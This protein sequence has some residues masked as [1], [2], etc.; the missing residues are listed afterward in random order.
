MR[1][2]LVISTVVGSTLLIGVALA[3]MSSMDHS[4]MPDM[5]STQGGAATNWTK[6][7][8]RAFDRAYLSM[9]IGHHQGAL[10]MSQAVVNRVKDAQVKKWAQAVIA[11]QT[12]EINTMTAWLRSM[13]GVQANMR[14]AMAKDMQGMIAPLRTAR[15]P[16]AAFVQGMLPHHASALD[17]AT[18][19]LQ[20]SNDDRVLKLSRDIIKAQADEMYA[21]KSWLAKR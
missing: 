4:N 5:N 1:K 7:S 17:M 20:K 2:N 3:Q 8:G 13:G 19:A 15:D 11:D 14:D 12:K 16:D 6:L 9:M 10:E 21:F 18:V